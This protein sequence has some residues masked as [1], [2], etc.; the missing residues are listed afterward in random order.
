[1]KTKEVNPK[2][3]A[4]ADALLGEMITKFGVKFMSDFNDVKQN[5]PLYVVLCELGE[6]ISPSPMFPRRDIAET[7]V[8]LCKKYLPGFKQKKFRI[9][10]LTAV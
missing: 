1:M 10:K 3:K 2:H 4:L 8:A 5:N 9:Y 6:E 7:F